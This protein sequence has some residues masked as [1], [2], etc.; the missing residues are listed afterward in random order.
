[1][2]SK[3][4]VST[5]TDDERAVLAVLEG[6]YSA[7]AKNDADSFAAWYVEDATV[8]MP[9]TYHKNRDEVRT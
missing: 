8:V 2:T 4:A 7:W 6:I 1:M 9:G 3:N 5:R